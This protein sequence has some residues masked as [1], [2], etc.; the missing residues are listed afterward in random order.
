MYI[1]PEAV[2]PEAVD[3]DAIDR[4]LLGV[5]AVRSR[6]EV[7][8]GIQAMG[9]EDGS[10]GLTLPPECA[11]DARAS[12]GLPPGDLAVLSAHALRD[13]DGGRILFA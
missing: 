5:K 9:S 1:H 13:V 12:I 8:A 4:P 11:V 2:D 7:P 6:Q 3:H 10:D